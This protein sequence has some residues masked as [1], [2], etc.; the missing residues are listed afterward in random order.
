MTERSL[1]LTTEQAKLLVAI[2]QA[3]VRQSAPANVAIGMVLAQHD[4][5]DGTATFL[6]LVEGDEPAL[7]VGLDDA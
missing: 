4:I 6:R 5:P 7:V 1:A 3:A 2:Q